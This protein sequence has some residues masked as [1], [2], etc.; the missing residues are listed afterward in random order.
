MRRH[1]RPIARSP[2]IA[3]LTVVLAFGVVAWEQWV[4]SSALAGHDGQRDPLFHW[5][6]DGTLTMVPALLAV[7]AGLRAAQR[8]ESGRS[9]AQALLV[10]GTC[11]AGLLV[12]MLTPLTLVHSGLDQ[13]SGAAA[14]IDPAPGAGYLVPGGPGAF[15]SLAGFVSH[16][17][18]GARDAL[19]AAPAALFLALVTLG[20]MSLRAAASEQDTVQSRPTAPAPHLRVPSPSGISKRE[21][22]KFGGAG[23]AAL[24]LGSTGL[25]VLPARRAHA[26][27]P[28]PVTPWLSDNIE[29]FINDGII[30]MIEGTPVYFWGWGFRS[31]AVDESAALNTPGPVLW[32]NHGESVSLSVTNNLNEE[33][34]FFIAG[35]V[36]SGPIAPGETR[37]V[38]FS[39]PSPGTYLYQD[40]LNQ[41]VNRTLGLNGVLIVMPA[42]G[43]LVAHPDLAA[44]HWTFATQWVWIF[45]EI[46]PAFNAR[47]Q[48][49]QSI[50]PADFLARFKPRYFTINGRMGSVANHQETA[51]DTTVHGVI[52]E[53]ALIR[54]VN[55]GV[56]MHGPHFHGNHVFPLLHNAAI[57]DVIMWKD[58]LKVMPADRVDVFLPFAIPPNAVHYPPPADGSA[59]LRQLHGREMEGKWPMHCHVEMSQTAA[60]GLYPQG[61]L[62]DWR[63]EQ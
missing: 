49:D 12:L 13:L 4:H 62:T 50:E 44:E 59:F 41:P 16:F 40:G 37:Q 17:G 7:W 55:A 3:V 60:G 5:L 61:L 15:E 28:E 54:I 9:L 26:A 52:G 19:V 43:S 45:N 21:L 48:A 33:H 46:D 57:P 36:D 34:S 58:T 10:R 24:A 39:A 51:P 1:V 63:V 42:D 31:G 47:A 20:V 38:S 30:E 29:L 25:I 27:E 56:A 6:R 8:F 18:H 14:D 53:P 32:T 35:V 23:A 2:E 11:V 22:L